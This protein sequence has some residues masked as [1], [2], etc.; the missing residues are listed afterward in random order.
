VTKRVRIFKS[1]LQVNKTHLFVQII[2]AVLYIM[3][4]LVVLDYHAH[5]PIL[6]AVGASSLASSAYLVFGLPDAHASTAKRVFFGYVIA[7]AA[8]EAVRW[9][10]I[11]FFCC[12]INH[13]YIVTSLGSGQHM[14]WL[15]AAV[16]VGLSLLL[17]ILF[18]CDHPPAAGLSLVLVIDLDHLS[19]VVVILSLALLLSII[20]YCAR[21]YLRDLR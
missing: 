13:H 6:W 12:D 17:M 2:A 3:L 18:D 7:A 15:S 19:A 8:G 1:N 4:V 9:L 11:W 21:G 5:S 16:A 14:Y 10:A 20:K